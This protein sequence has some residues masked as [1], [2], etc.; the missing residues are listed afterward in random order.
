MQRLIKLG[1]GEL[2]CIYLLGRKLSCFMVF[3]VY[4]QAAL[5][6]TLSSLLLP[7]PAPPTLSWSSSLIK[8][9]S[10]K[11]YSFIIMGGLHFQSGSITF[12]WLIW[13]DF[14]K[15][16]LE[17][18]IVVGMRVMLRE[19]NYNYFIDISCISGI[20]QRGRGR[21]VHVKWYPWNLSFLTL[22][23]TANAWAYVV[24]IMYVI[25]TKFFMNC[26]CVPIPP[27]T[28]SMSINEPCN[29]DYMFPTPT[30]G[31]CKHFSPSLWSQHIPQ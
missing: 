23:A 24:N 5:E 6:S 18:H 13:F 15:L 12:N 30:R 29:C 22:R 1:V 25:W 27:C 20:N 7:P 16:K 14:L 11:D 2:D 10:T 4:N 28:M 8:S 3:T 17:E 26:I 9:Q 31:I 19:W 21:K